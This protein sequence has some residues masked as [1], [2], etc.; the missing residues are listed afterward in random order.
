MNPPTHFLQLTDHGP[1]F[2]REVL[3]RAASLR[4]DLRSGKASSLFAGKTLAMIFEHPSLR[5][6]VSFEVAMTQLSGHAIYLAPA[7]IGLNTREPAGDVARVLGS[8][9]D[10]VMARVRSQSTLND[11]AATCPVPVINGL[12]DL[13]HPCQALADLLTMRDAFGSDLAGRRVCY[14]GD[15]NNVFRSLAVACGM[16]GVSVVGCSPDGYALPADEA[17]RLRRQV[18]SL[19][20]TLVADPQEAVKACD[21]LYT[22]VWASMG[23]EAEREKRL[24]AFAGYG[25]T[26]ALLAAA[27]PDAIVLHCLPAHR[28]EEIDADVMASPQ[29]RIFEQAENRLHAQKGLLAMLMA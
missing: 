4:S 3:D 23:Q 19:D 26:G 12:S 14:I 10:C 20:L 7:D 2:V 18:S 17:E 1:D 27:E 29:S 13:A 9:T 22:D 24:A 16:V 6:R 28:G 15:A 11:L 5:T 21:V 8:M 25:I